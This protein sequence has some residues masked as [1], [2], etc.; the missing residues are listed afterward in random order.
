MIGTLPVPGSITGVFSMKID[1]V[2]IDLILQSDKRGIYGRERD[3][4]KGFFKKLFGKKDDADESSYYQQRIVEIG[5]DE[6]VEE[7]SGEIDAYLIEKADPMTMVILTESY[8]ILPGRE[9]FPL[10]DIDQFAIGSVWLPPYQQYALDREGEPYDPDYKSEFE[11]EEGYELDRFNIDF[12]I[13]DSEIATYAYTFP[14][15]VADR[16]DFRDKL[17]EKC[18]AEDLSEDPVFEGKFNEEWNVRS[19]FWKGL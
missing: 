12:V 10:M 16:S 19:L 1:K 4:E 13:R 5:R 3:E 17:N 7:L 2:D 18:D 11:E 9:I 14:M 15:E 6:L 8:F